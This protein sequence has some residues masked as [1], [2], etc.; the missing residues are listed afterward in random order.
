VGRSP[1]CG[2]LVEGS[3]LVTNETM[4]IVLFPLFFAAL[5]L[6]AGALLSTVSGWP[7]LARRFPAATEP[8]GTTLKGQVY[9]LGGVGEN[10]VTALTVSAGGLHLKAHFLFRFLRPAILVPWSEVR[11]V[12]ERKI[13]WW[14]RYVLELGGATKIAIGE[15]AFR[16]LEGFLTRTT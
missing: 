14:R 11:F 1:A 15:Q 5:W 6:T 8:S 10:N 16:A 13:L 12:S 2:G 4:P 3:D 7:R 9:S